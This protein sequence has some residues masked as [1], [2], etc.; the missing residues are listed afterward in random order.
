VDVPLCEHRVG[1]VE[2]VRGRVAGPPPALL[3]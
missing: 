3:A 2:H 1:E